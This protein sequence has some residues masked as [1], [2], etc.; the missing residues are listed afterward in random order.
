[1]SQRFPELIL[2]PDKFFGPGAD[3]AG[4]AF[5]IGVHGPRREAVRMGV[6]DEGETFGATWRPDIV[7]S[8]LHSLNGPNKLECF[9]T[10]R[11]KGWP[12]TNIL[13]F[14]AHL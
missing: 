11:W 3:E 2:A 12:E 7:F 13:A 6:E 8:S 9:I 5:I 1:M 4:E 10:M 14:W